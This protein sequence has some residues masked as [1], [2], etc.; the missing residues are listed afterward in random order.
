MNISLL[1]QISV[2]LVI[3]GRM[4][5]FADAKGFDPNGDRIDDDKCEFLSI[6]LYDKYHFFVM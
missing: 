6:N 5:T 1:G 4:N 3:F 2:I